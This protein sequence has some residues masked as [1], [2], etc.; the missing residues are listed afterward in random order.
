[1]ATRSINE[2]WSDLDNATHAVQELLTIYG[3][4]TPEDRFGALSVTVTET[5]YRIVKELHDQIRSM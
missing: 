2:I 1:M 5:L 4:I 3:D